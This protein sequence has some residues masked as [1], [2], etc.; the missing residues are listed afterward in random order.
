MTIDTLAPNAPSIT[1]IAENGGG[2]INAAEVSNGTPV[3][4]GLAGTGGGGRH[5][6]NWVETVTYTLVAADISGS[7]ATV[8]V[9][10]GT[11]TTRARHVQR[12]G[13]ADRHSGQYRRQLDGDVGDGRHGGADGEGCDHGDCHLTAARRPATTSPTTRC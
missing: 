2:G 9:P 1:S 4:V 12:D 5:V 8:T 13:P 10:L 3:V 11:L 7:S 6:I